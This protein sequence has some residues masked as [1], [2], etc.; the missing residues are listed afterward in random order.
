MR[1]SAA[2]NRHL[3]RYPDHLADRSWPA[4]G[5]HSTAPGEEGSPYHDRRSLPPADAVD[6]NTAD[7][8]CLT[9]TSPII[10]DPYILSVYVS[11][12][13]RRTPL[14]SL[15]ECAPLRLPGAAAAP[16]VTR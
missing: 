8:P 2:S 15:R 1:Q 11:R 12:R 9:S 7:F 6:R 3:S 10:A 14:C 13:I 16:L 4:K 5:R